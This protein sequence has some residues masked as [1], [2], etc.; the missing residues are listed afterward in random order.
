VL[1]IEN[2]PLLRNVILDFR[3]QINGDAGELVLS[4]DFEKVDM[5][6]SA[7]LIT[8][9]FNIDFESKRMAGKITQTA[10]EAGNTF[11]EDKQ[12]ILCEINELAARISI[13]MPFDSSFSEMEDFG[14]IIKLLS[15]HFEAEESDVAGQLIEYIRMQREFF[16]K[17]LFIVY[18]LK[19]CLSEEELTAFYKTAFYEKLNILII[20]D[21]QRGTPMDCENTVIIDN[22][23]CVLM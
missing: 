22:D 12:K 10:I 3:R 13:S 23:L 15:F 5:S 21:C 7:V 20:E 9:P 17:E 11:A 18:N 1:V 16:G 2:K 6:K 8:N 4:H 14:G 19:A